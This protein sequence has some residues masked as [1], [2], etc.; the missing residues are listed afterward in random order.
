MDKTKFQKFR[1]YEITS[2]SLGDFMAAK[3]GVL[4][5]ASVAKRKGWGVG[6]TIDLRTQFGLLM[7]VKGIFFS[8]N[9]EQDN[10]IITDAEYVQ[11]QMA[12]R[13]KANMVLIKLKPNVRAEDVAAEIDAMPLA[14]RTSTQAEKAFVSGMVEDLNDM[15]DISR[16]VI[17]ITLAVVFVSV[18]NT[19]SMSVRDR[20]KQ[21]GVLRTLGF[22]RSAVLG[23]IVT[24][25]AMICLTGGVIG[26]SLAYGVL[27]FQ[28]VSIQ[29][30]S[31]NL[32]V[33]LPLEVVGLA[34]AVAAGVGVLGS[35]I[36]AARASR[37]KIVDALGSVG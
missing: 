17:L 9:E 8:G 2:G 3:D 30:R 15:I 27:H 35:I 18:A 32:A 19:V 16:L 12:T 31:L 22:R 5:G 36:P 10:T 21:I 28:D 34:L 37:M 23:L 25:S 6:Q 29:A 4:A 14:T 13:G 1:H 20:T 33:S 26:V 24:E 7:V 11:D